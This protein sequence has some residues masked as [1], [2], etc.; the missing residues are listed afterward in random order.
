MNCP[1]KILAGK[2]AVT[3]VHFWMN[4]MTFYLYGV[5]VI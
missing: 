4:Y 3:P 2:E 1:L 5:S